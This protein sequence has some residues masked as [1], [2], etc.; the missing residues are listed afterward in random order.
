MKAEELRFG[1]NSRWSETLWMVVNKR[2][3]GETYE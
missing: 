1:R 2:Q 3:D